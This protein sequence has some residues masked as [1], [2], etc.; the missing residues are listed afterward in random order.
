MTMIAVSPKMQTLIQRSVKHQ[1][2]RAM[3]V[4]SKQS[5]EE[6]KKLVRLTLPDR[7]EQMSD[8][9][10]SVSVWTNSWCLFDIFRI[11]MLA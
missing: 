2:T 10:R 5:G 8:K 11:T 1:G 9:K 7:K 6:Y 3:T 4:L